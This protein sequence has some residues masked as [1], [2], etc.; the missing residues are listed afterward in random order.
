MTN[1]TSQTTNISSELINHDV[2]RL[3]NIKTLKS[4]KAQLEKVSREFEAIFI[5]KMLNTMNK[6]V[7]KEGGIFGNEDKYMDKF[8]AFIY[9]EIGRDIAA[10]PRTS[11]GFAK[12][13]Y[14]QMERYLPKEPEVQTQAITSIQAKNYEKE[15]TKA[16]AQTK[17]NVDR[18][19]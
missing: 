19:I 4:P 14:S 7:D 2:Q 11:V 18:E 10:N 6:T 13:I 5:T 15:A 16:V 12:Q 9:D 1:I 8:K 3:G 17:N